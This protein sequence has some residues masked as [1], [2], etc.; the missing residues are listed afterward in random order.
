LS[1]RAV[2]STHVPEHRRPG[3]AVP[4]GD[5][6]LGNCHQFALTCRRPPGVSGFVVSS[7]EWLAVRN[8]I[9]LVPLPLYQQNAASPYWMKVLP[10]QHAVYLKYNQ[11]LSGDGF[12]QLAARASPT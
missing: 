8:Q 7:I 10:V 12:Q 4:T 6:A 9:V 2:D 3:W 5:H 11:C 1:S